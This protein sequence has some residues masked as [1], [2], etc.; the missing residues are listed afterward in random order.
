MSNG[1]FAALREA[2]AERLK[3]DMSECVHVGTSP[4]AVDEAEIATRM[5]EVPGPARQCA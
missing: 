3:R 5:P 1:G 4:G 2:V